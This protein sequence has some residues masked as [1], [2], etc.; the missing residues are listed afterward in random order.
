MDKV[1]VDRSND[2]IVFNTETNSIKHTASLLEIRGIWFAEEDGQVITDTE[3]VDY[4]KDDLVAI[5]TYFGR[6][7]LN[8]VL[9]I[10]D[11]AGKADVAEFINKC[12]KDE[13]ETI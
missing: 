7:T 10:S 9:I 1:L 5:M 2:I 13:N 4:K 3:V 6:R 11:M 12:K 8:K